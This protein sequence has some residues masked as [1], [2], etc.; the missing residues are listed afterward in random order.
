MYH[1]PIG[2]VVTN[3]VAWTKGVSSKYG[4]GGGSGLQGVSFADRDCCMYRLP[5]RHMMDVHV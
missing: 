3:K 4:N 1:L 2:I 5:K